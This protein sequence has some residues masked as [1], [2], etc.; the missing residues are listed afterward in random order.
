[1]IEVGAGGGAAPVTTNGAVA[2]TV[3]PLFAKNRAS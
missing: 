1:M 2:V 3:Q